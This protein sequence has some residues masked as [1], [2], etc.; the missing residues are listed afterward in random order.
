MPRR[1]LS[2]EGQQRVLS[3]EREEV[4]I[5]KK[6]VRDGPTERGAYEQ[7]PGGVKE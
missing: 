3:G 4:G 1:K 6:M 2:R 7:S 5:L